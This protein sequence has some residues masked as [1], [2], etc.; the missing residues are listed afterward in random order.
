ML[1]IGYFRAL[2][3]QNFKP[4]FS[5]AYSFGEHSFPVLD[6]TT[7]RL[8]YVSLCCGENRL[9]HSIAAMKGFDYGFPPLLNYF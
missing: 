4:G 8:V 7:S 1:T 3:V 5:E 6:S 2:C 9:K